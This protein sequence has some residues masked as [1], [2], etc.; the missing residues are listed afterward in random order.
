MRLTSYLLLTICLHVSA[1]TFSQSVTFSGKAVTMEKLFTAIKKQTGFVVW[2]KSELLQQTI[3]V[4]VSAQHMPLTSF[5][6]LIMKDQPIHYKIAGNTIMLYSKHALPA[7]DEAT[8]DEKPVPVTGRVTDSTGAPLPG[9]TVLVAGSKQSAITGTDGNFTINANAGDVIRIS[10][11]GYLAKEITITADMLKTGNI[12]AITLYIVT[13]TLS[14]V[15]VIAYTGYQAIPKERVTGAFS[16]ITEKTLNTR[17]ETNILDRLEGTVAGLYIQNGAVNVRG[18]S[19][20]YGNQAPLY[21][22]DGFPY[23]GDINLINPADVINVTVMKDAAAASIYGTRAANGVISITTRLGNSRKPIVS[24]SSTVFMTPIPN[25]GYLHLLNASQMVGLQQE[26]FNMWHPPFNDAIRRGAQPKA[27]EALYNYEQQ[28]ISKDQLDSILD[29]LSQANGQS[30]I[31]DLLMRKML[32]QRHSFSASGGNE[33]HQY[34]LTMNYTGNRGYALSTRDESVNVGIKDR[35]KVFNWLDAE[36]GAITNFNN[37]SVNQENPGSYYTGMPYEVLKNPDG[38][39]APWNYLKSPYEIDRLKSLGLYDETFNPLN[40]LHKSDL[41]YWSNY[42]RLQGGFTVKITNGLNFELKYQTERGASNSKT[43]YS[44]DS[45]YS[46]NMINDAAQIVNGEVVKNVPDGGQIYETRG[47]ARSYTA[48]AQL[49]YNRR[50]NTH[51]YI[52]ALAGTERRAVAQSST[53]VF[54]LGYNDNNLQYTP[55]NEA[56]LG[57]LKGTESL[58]SNFFYDYTSHNNF[59]YGE[60]RYISAFGNAGYTYNDKYNVTASVRV[61]NSNLFGTDPRYRY[62]PLWSVGASWRMSE[63]N[64]MKDITWLNS[65]SIRSTYGLSGNIARQVGPYLQAG[66]SFSSEAN[67]P[68]TDILYPPN[69]SLRWEKTA[70]T[71]IGVDFALFN[72]RI[73]GSADYYIRKS[74]D[75][76]GEKATDP[77]NAFTSALINY[78]SLSNK[79]FEV[80]LNTSNIQQKHFSWNTTLTLSLNK[81]RMTKINTKYETVDGLTAG[82]GVNRIGYPMDAVFSF[83]W[84]G[85]DPANGSV[86]LYGAAG[87]VVKNYDQDGNIVANMTD[88]NALAY[89]GTLRPTYTS[90]LTNTFTYQQLS[91]SIMIIANGGNVLRDVPPAISYGGLTQNTDSRVMNFWRQ[92]GDE[93]KTGTLPAPDLKGNGGNYYTIIW[94]AADKNVLKADYIK[95]RD[96]SLSYNFSPALFHTKKLSAVKL[97]LQVQN[98]FHWYRNAAGIDPEAYQLSSSYAIRTLPV[99]PTYMAGINITF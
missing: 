2:G 14:D 54:R 75:L 11:V 38:S 89:S 53:T 18:L 73:A 82:Y 85:L 7:N 61:D 79:G 55:I 33:V 36:V 47:D 3:P 63:E 83:K 32:K 50:I 31:E 5:L 6:Q 77:T 23:E 40:E 68:A 12:G 94:Y 45:Y 21:V 90:G 72:N 95:V 24:F 62:L 30:Q 51:H 78:G 44:S 8:L 57:S 43:C 69:K 49:N 13:S 92:P 15:N 74:T 87:K 65:L 84:A 20:I 42:F 99:T 71:N 16:I 17:M 39:L 60:D 56:N 67:A 91:L 66:A 27:T 58:S 97:M 34:N 96:I 98:P 37:G 9:A 41:S 64:F 76:L 28:F 4:S 29:R 52:S 1:S 88:V 59:H 22:V 48:R 10:F 86:M 19:T 70:T 26:L 93:K 81:N 25:A 80:T 35:I 46:K